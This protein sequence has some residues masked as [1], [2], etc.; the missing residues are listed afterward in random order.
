VKPAGEPASLLKSFG[1]AFS[2]LAF[3]LRSQRNAR[4]HAGITLGV[5]A[6]AV[7]LNLPPAQWALLVLAMGLVWTA[8]SINTALEELVDLCSPE[9]DPVA[10]AAK[11]L[12]AAAVLL[13]AGAAA[14]TGVLVLGPELLRRA[15]GS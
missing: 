5:I 12:A 8:E 14:V 15:A 10:R 4:I 3:L 2:G 6:L 7:W 9:I 11:D 13:A 1:H